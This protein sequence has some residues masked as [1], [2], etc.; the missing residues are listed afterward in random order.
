MVMDCC[1]LVAKTCPTLL[2]TL[3][4]VACQEAPLSMGFSKQEYWRGLPFPSSGDP[5]NPRIKCV[6]PVLAG[7][8]FTT[9]PPEKL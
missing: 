5:P 9:E 6:F 4:T 1:C 8:F 2:G 7:R 3:W